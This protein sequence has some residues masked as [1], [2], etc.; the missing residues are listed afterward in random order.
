MPSS[1]IADDIVIPAPGPA[2]EQPETPAAIQVLNRTSYNIDID[3]FLM[4]T[5]AITLSADKPQVLIIHTHSSEAYCETSS[6]RTLDRDLNVMKV[7]AVLAEELTAQGINVI[8]DTGIYDYPSYSGSYSRSLEAVENYLEK[9][10]SIQIVFD[11]HRDSITLGDGT[12]YRTLYT[13]GDFSSAQVML[14]VATGEAGLNHPNWKENLKFG[15]RLQ[16]SM[17]DSY[18]GLARPLCI[19]GERYNQHTAPGSILIEIGTD[20]N[21]IDEAVNAARLFASAAGP[22]IKEL[23]EGP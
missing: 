7:G 21:S 23:A 5:P 14:L 20:G 3:S 18:P 16:K 1:V 11:I 17:E 19:S 10:P 13:L 4:E 12:K 8:H 9:H 2:Q 6:S 22:V 15:L